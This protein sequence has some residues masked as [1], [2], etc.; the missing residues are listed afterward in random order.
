MK[1]SSLRS[2]INFHSYHIN[3]IYLLYLFLMILHWE[4]SFLEDC[5]S[6]KVILLACWELFALCPLS[7][8]KII[9]S[10][11][12]DRGKEPGN[13]LNTQYNAHYPLNTG[14]ICRT[15]EGVLLNVI[16]HTFN[17]IQMH[18]SIQLFTVFIMFLLFPSLASVW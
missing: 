9:V 12:Q 3:M 1:I 7:F 16:N 15:N 8:G 14:F 11:M 2:A 4:K 10:T 13:P 5:V 18:S 6:R 17:K